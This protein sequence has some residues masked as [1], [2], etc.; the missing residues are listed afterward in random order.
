MNEF[1][2]LRRNILINQ[3]KGVSPVSYLILTDETRIDFELG[4]TP[5][6]NFCTNFASITVNGQSISKNSIKEIVFGISY[7]TVSY[8]SEMFIY[9]MDN[10]IKIDFRG[11]GT[12][13][14]IG[15]N[16]VGHCPK[17]VE[18]D[19][20]FISAV[21]YIPGNFLNYCTG[22]QSINIKPLKSSYSLGYSFLL[23]C[24]G[25]S[26]IDLSEL[27]E[28]VEISSGFMGYC[29]NLN[30]IQI[31]GIDWNLIEVYDGPYSFQNIPNQSSRFIYADTLT[32]ANNFK[33]KFPNLSNWSIAIG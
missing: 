9:S 27:D 31:G 1:E 5:I 24:S 20:N 7:N 22:L 11:L 30:S 28:L 29:T 12:I 6:V 33:A 19:L 4:N 8:I 16:F 15:T 3:G 21:D 32:L 26:S 25:L 10:L 23:E 17:L 2:R 14:N 13:S 18:V